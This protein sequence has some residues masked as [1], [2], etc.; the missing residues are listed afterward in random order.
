MPD[1]SRF[2]CLAYAVAAA[3]YLGYALLLT[4][5]RKRVRAQRR[6]GGSVE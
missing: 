2:F 3:I 5:R 4:A 6:G 1:N